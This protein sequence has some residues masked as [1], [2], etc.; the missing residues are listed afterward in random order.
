[1][2]LLIPGALGWG[3]SCFLLPREQP[4]C[5]PPPYCPAGTSH[6]QGSPGNSPL[7]R[8]GVEF[9][10]HRLAQKSLFFL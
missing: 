9:S 1:M 4:G 3:C 5:Y 10:R 8:Q 2:P 6:P 7:Q